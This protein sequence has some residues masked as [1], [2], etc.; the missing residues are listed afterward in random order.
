MRRA[1]KILL[2][3]T[4]SFGWAACTNSPSPPSTGSPRPTNPIAVGSSLSSIRAV[5]RTAYFFA[6]DGIH[7]SEL[8]MSDGTGSGTSLVKDI[9]RGPRGSEGGSLREVGGLLFFAADDGV[10]GP[11]LWK[12]DGTRSG[13]VM[14][15]DICR[16]ECSDG[17]TGSYAESFVALDDT[18]YFPANDGVHGFQL[19]KTDGTAAGTAM[20]LDIR[21]VVPHSIFLGDLTEAG[22]ALFFTA[23]VD[24]RGDLGLFKSDGTAAGTIHVATFGRY[25]YDLTDVAGVLFMGT[26]DGGLYKSDGTLDG[27]VALGAVR[28]YWLTKVD[29]SVFFGAGRSRGHGG[30]E[31]WKSDG[32]TSGTL[33]VKD[34][35]PGSLGPS[36]LIDVGG[37]LFFVGRDP[38]HGR[39]LWRSGGTASGTSLVK[40]IESGKASS[41][42]E[43]FAQVGGALFFIAND[44]THGSELWRSDGTPSGTALV[45]DIQPGPEGSQAGSLANVGGVLF[46]EADDG[47]H[48]SELWKSDGTP[49]GTVLVMDVNSTQ[50]TS[51][52]SG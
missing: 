15:K 19:W 52:A 16:G 46:F 41:T 13:T 38:I 48:G 6:D 35:A 29:G 17:Q 44:G 33:L 28:P 20:V 26:Y 10:H 37:T 9:M 11:E 40:D 31:L 27:T 1:W 22:G 32:T 39:E 4:V 51:F 8:W 2:A 21:D 25:L 50:T 30:I 23:E 18:T 36:K 49:S 24:D 34:I 14:V 12:S 7:G 47:V 43:G 3:M 42:P 45:K 5:G